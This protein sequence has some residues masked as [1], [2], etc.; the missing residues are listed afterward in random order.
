MKRREFITFWQRGCGM[1]A[2]GA[3]AAA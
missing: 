1:A 3:R 2:C